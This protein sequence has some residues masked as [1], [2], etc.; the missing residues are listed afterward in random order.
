[1]LFLVVVFLGFEC[2]FSFV[3]VMSVFF[4][5]FGSVAILSLYMGTDFKYLWNSN[6]RITLYCLVYYF[7]SNVF[8][9]RDYSVWNILTF[10]SSSSSGFTLCVKY[11]IIVHFTQN[12]SCGLLCMHMP[13]YSVSS[14]LLIRFCGIY[15]NTKKVYF[16]RLVGF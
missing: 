12:T 15:W 8:D 11:N 7:F 14:W 4:G 2:L 13:G 16:N 5:K 10:C 9:F 1:M 3:K 6:L